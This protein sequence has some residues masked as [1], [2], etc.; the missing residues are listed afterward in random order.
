MSIPFLYLTYTSQNGNGS[1]DLLSSTS[2]NSKEGR[3]SNEV[4]QVAH[5]NQGLPTPPTH[6]KVQ[7]LTW[8]MKQTSVHFMCHQKIFSA[9]DQ[10][11]PQA[12]MKEQTR[13][14]RRLTVP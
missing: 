8:S 5:S 12:T 2:D 7:E 9:G 13:R 6:H 1:E 11:L 3:Q 14:Y 10:V 4:K